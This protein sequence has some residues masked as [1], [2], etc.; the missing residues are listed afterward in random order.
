MLILV[1][2][3]KKSHSQY[4]NRFSLFSFCDWDSIK[5]N[6]NIEEILMATDFLHSTACWVE[7]KQSW[8]LTLNGLQSA[9]NMWAMCSNDQKLVIGR[10]LLRRLSCQ[11][12]WRMSK[13][14][15]LC[16]SYE[17]HHATNI[18]KSC[19]NND[20]V[21]RRV[22]VYACTKHLQVEDDSVWE[23]S[24]KKFSVQRR[25]PCCQLCITA[26]LTSAAS[27]WGIQWTAQSYLCNFI[28]LQ[29]L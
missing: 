12:H 1:L 19:I 8:W 5:C 24:R 9:N 27:H 18:F 28:P 21:E 6:I 3:K 29:C 15:P 22:P 23:V 10:S 4:E 11:I 20:C 2:M 7:G 25:Q 13:K 16:F 14:K 26:P 17:L